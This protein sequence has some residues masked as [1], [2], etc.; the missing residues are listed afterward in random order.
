[1][2]E[3]ARDSPPGRPPQ[4]LA[5]QEKDRRKAFLNCWT[6]KEALIKGLG[7][8]LFVPLDSFDVTLSPRE[9][10]R[11]RASRLD[12]K[13]STS[14]WRTLFDRRIRTH[15][16]HHEWQESKQQS[17]IQVELVPHLHGQERVHRPEER[18]AGKQIHAGTLQLP[19][20]RSGQNEPT[21]SIFL[22]QRVND[23]QEIRHLLDLV[24]HDLRQV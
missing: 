5:L 13:A 18:P 21:V 19:R 15:A 8:G 11:L 9:A 17:S 6:R 2:S 14:A 7:D 23:S 12:S 16:V 1:M 22:D 10:A 24:D 3:A 4:L 20:A